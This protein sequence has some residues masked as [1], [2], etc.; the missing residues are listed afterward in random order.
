MIYFATAR[1][2]Y[3]ATRFL[4]T[5]TWRRPCR[6]RLVRNSTGAHYA[7]AVYRPPRGMPKRTKKIRSFHLSVP[8][9]RVLDLTDRLGYQAARVFVGLGAD[10]VRVALH[11][12][13]D[14]AADRLHWHAGKKVLRH[15][16]T[17]SDATLIEL[18]TQ[19]DVVLESRPVPGFRTLALRDTQ[20]S[21]WTGIVHTVITP[22]GTS[23]P[24]REWLGDDTV[25]TAAGGMA[26]LCGDAGRPPNH[27]RAS[28]V[29]NSPAP[30]V[31][32]EHSS[33]SLPDVERPQVNWSRSPLRKL[34]PPHSRSVPS[35]GYTAG[36]FPDAHP[37]STVML[38]TECSGRPTGSSP[39]ATPDPPHVD[40]PS[41]LDGRRGRGRGSGR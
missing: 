15:S 30:T 24:R 11:E 7:I 38:P 16:G 41:G 19:T 33:P 29:P 28:R 36:R 8:A 17:V 9:I 1:R 10:V 3:R 32:S 37:A 4:V 18:I 35:R 6:P 23:G 14:S 22:F 39:A 20:P 25:I 13:S 12:N 31:P 40:G 26:W 21:L 5:S 27:R 34:S 2:N